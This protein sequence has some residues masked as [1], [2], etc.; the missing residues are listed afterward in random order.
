V[1]MGSRIIPIFSGTALRSAVLRDVS[2]WLILLGCAIRVLF[3]SL[4]E[5]LGPAYLKLTS[6][7]G[8]LELGGIILFAY[9]VWPALA[10][11]RGGEKGAAQEARA[12]EGTGTAA[13][14][15]GHRHAQ[16]SLPILPT[17]S[18]GALLE[19]RPDLLDVF[20]ESGFVQ[21]A[22]PILRR[23]LARYVSIARAC[24]MHGVDLETFLERLRRDGPQSTAG[25]V[26]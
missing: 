21:L 12:R 16:D 11:A 17:T 3:Q 23:T 4:S 26:R 2:Y 1:G 7:S 19:A 9:N 15:G 8:L 25:G 22:N 14:Q 24:G 10:A 5:T 20:V 18:V 13:T 6:V